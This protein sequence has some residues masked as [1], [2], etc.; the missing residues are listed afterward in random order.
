MRAPIVED[1]HVGRPGEF[2]Q[3]LDLR[4]YGSLYGTITGGILKGW[5][6]TVSGAALTCLPSSAIPVSAEL[7][8]SLSGPSFPKRSR[9]GQSPGLVGPQPYGG[10]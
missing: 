5:D 7:A 10:R 9:I 6:W 2:R 1:R 8:P 4:C 3:L